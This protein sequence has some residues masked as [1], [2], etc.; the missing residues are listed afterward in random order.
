MAPLAG[1]VLLLGLIYVGLALITDGAYALLAGSLRHWLGGTVLRGPLPRYLTG[2]L[3]IGLGVNAA[4]A[5]RR[6]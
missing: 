1:Q 3:Y 4:L 2:F 6:G 5:G